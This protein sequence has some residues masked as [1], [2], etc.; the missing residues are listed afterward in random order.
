ML[1][2][3]KDCGVIPGSSS[4]YQV[5][6]LYITPVLEPN[7]SFCPDVLLGHMFFAHLSA[8][9]FC[10]HGS[11]DIIMFI[12]M[13]SVLLGTSSSPS[14]RIPCVCGS[15]LLSDAA[16]WYS[17]TRVSNRGAIPTYLVL[18]FW[19]INCLFNS[20]QT[21]LVLNRSISKCH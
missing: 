12:A 14:L 19:T 13:S 21:S 10:S 11:L 15:L 7:I 16:F 8:E 4:F 2:G 5:E 6:Y 9:A 18:S 17:L 20:H 3:T 1:R